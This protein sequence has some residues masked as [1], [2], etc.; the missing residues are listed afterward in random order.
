MKNPF[1]GYYSVLKGMPLYFRLFI[2]IAILLLGFSVMGFLGV[3]I[4]SLVTG[5]PIASFS[6]PEN[7]E[8]V[9]GIATGFKIIQFFL[10]IGIFVIPALLLPIILFATN[11]VSFMGI[12]KRSAFILFVIAIC[13]AL[14]IQPIVDF[15]TRI[16]QHIV[17]PHFLSGLENYIKEQETKNEA[18]MMQFLNMPHL[19]DFIVNI[20]IVAILP[21]IVE[22]LFFRGFVQ[23]ALQIWLKR[24]HLAVFIAAFIFSF[25]HFEFYGFIPRLL[26]GMLMGY[27]YLWSGDIK[28]PIMIHFTNNF[29]DLGLSYY[30]QLQGKA[31]EP[32]NTSTQPSIL[33]YIGS[34]IF[35]VVLL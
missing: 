21:A 14:C 28:L 8:G 3:S 29:L 18:L 5:Q 31:P 13:L 19:I 17:F 2:G 1:D 10:D 15:S 6:H 16:N 23:K 25:I 11:P 4:A 33:L 26:L 35:M 24:S 9:N 22:E 27:A 30:L 12:N 20:F 7:A 32:D 34:A